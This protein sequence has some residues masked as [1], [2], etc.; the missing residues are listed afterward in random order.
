MDEFYHRMVCVD[1]DEQEIFGHQENKLVPIKA[2][3]SVLGQVKSVK[4]HTQNLKQFYKENEI[5]ERLIE[6][7]RKFKE[8][9]D[10]EKPWKEIDK[11][12]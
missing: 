3:R 7:E 8:N 4:K 6:V 2:R 9:P 10:D 1:F 5:K 11:D 12:Q